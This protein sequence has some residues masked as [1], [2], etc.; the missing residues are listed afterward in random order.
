MSMEKDTLP[1]N[2]KSKKSKKFKTSLAETF[3]NEFHEKVKPVENIPEADFIAQKSD[4]ETRKKIVKGMVFGIRA[5]RDGIRFS[6]CVPEGLKDSEL[7]GIK[8][9]G[10]GLTVKVKG[11]G[12]RI[13]KFLL[14]GKECEPF[15]PWDDKAHTVTMIME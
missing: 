2:E 8:L 9:R 15:I 6:P 3:D 10:N 7:G 13:G 4:K 5:E 11:Y 12:S 14:D 1:A